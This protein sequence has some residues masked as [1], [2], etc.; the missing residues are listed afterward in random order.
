M[1]PYLDAGT[2]TG[3]ALISTFAG[4][5]LLTGSLCNIVVAERA[6]ASGTPLGFMDFARSGIPMTLVSVAIAAF[7]PYLT[8]LMRW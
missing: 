3:L 5:L 6:Q 1:L 8:G 2:L 7:W 4:N